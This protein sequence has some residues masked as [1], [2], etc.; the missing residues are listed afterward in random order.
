MCTYSICY[1]EKNTIYCEK[2]YHL[3]RFEVEEIV[4]EMNAKNDGKTY[5]IIKGKIY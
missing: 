2:V 4:E 3:M 5:F 1:E